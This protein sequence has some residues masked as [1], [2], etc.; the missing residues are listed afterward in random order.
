M[1][2]DEFKRIC[3]SQRMTQGAMTALLGY[4]KRN[5]N[6][7]HQHGIPRGVVLLVRLLGDGTI[8]PAD[9]RRVTN[10]VESR[11]LLDDDPVR[12]AQ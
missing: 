10:G 4:N 2:K 6:G 9:I 3:K 11:R 5:Y 8:T 12:R 1:T 7:W